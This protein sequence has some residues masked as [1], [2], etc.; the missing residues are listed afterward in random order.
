M[1]KNIL[2]L[3]VLTSVMLFLLACNNNTVSEDKKDE[4]QN[5]NST[6]ENIET[7][8][9]STVDDLGE[10]DFGG[11]EFKIMNWTSPNQA[12]L[13]GRM[14]FEVETGDVYQ[15]EIYR[16]NRRLEERFNI[17]LSIRLVE[18][19]GNPIMRTQLLADGAE[20]DL[21][22][23]I[24]GVS[25]SY[26]SE[27]LINEISR[28]KHIDLSKAYWDDFMTKQL[29]IANKKYFAIGAFDFTA[30]DLCYVV[31]ANK[32]LLQTYGLEDPFTLVKD[33]KWTINKFAEM[34]KT[35]TFDL[36]GDGIMTKDDAWGYVAR[37][38]DVMPG[39]WC[40]AG[41]KASDHD[42]DDILQNL[43]GTERFINVIDKI[44][45]ITWG[46]ET[47]YN[48]FEFDMFTAGNT[49]FN[50]C[51][52]HR[53]KYLRGMETDFGILP[54][55]KWDESQDVYYSRMA[56]SACYFT[57]KSAP[58]ESVDRTGVILE[59]MAS[60]SYANVLPAYY[61]TVL[62]TKLARDEESA[63]II[64]MICANK[65]VDWI[66][67]VWIG[68]FRDGPLD[69]MFRSKNNTLV[70]LNESRLNPLF[71]KNRD[72]LVDMV[73]ALDD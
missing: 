8:D 10:Y 7:E 39:L 54:Y 45:D 3:L 62:K 70:S 13:D 4:T 15:D 43:M 33:G 24:M 66:D 30:Y 28:F 64:D 17:T 21:Y 72:M 14:N 36:N 68:D 2:F 61:E 69:V 67:A 27:G 73:M 56:G 52:L 22:T 60:D 47:Y 19:A 40:G 20:Y 32:Q 26:A 23:Q 34:C 31:L 38:S 35:A 58:D 18:G 46:Q 42:G 55:P 29:T 57:S 5:T 65:V 16:R 11:H 63:E 12:F 41:V 59:A 6:I 53:L 50:D 44:F 49:L 25:F 1:K 37:S 9:R 48:M 51:S 71:I